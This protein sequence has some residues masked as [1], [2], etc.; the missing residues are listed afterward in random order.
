MKSS[1]S[2][3][4]RGLFGVVQCRYTNF[5]EFP[6]ET[7]AADFGAVFELTD[8]FKH[9]KGA[10]RPSR[11]SWRSWLSPWPQGLGTKSP[12]KCLSVEEIKQLKCS[13]SW[14]FLKYLEINCFQIA[15]LSCNVHLS[16]H[17]GITDYKRLTQWSIGLYRRSQPTGGYSKMLRSWTHFFLSVQRKKSIQYT[18]VY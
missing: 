12:E 14:T 10:L 3:N 6:K 15:L 5:A 16:C 11:P 18:I 8:H 7:S 13:S 17:W 1:H 2:D 9:L 4:F